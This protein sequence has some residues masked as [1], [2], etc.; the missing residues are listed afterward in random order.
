MQHHSRLCAL[1]ESQIL[2]FLGDILIYLTKIL[3]LQQ[4]KMVKLHIK[5]KYFARFVSNILWCHFCGLSE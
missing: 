4:N 5:E 3:I 1:A 2:T